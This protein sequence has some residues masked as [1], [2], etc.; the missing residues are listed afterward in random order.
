MRK[1]FLIFLAALSVFSCRS[2]ILEDRTECPSFLYF[3]VSNPEQFLG[4]QRV[5]VSAFSYPDRTFLACDTTVLSKMQD[6]SFYLEVKKSDAAMGHGAIGF[7]DG[8]LRDG[9]KWVVDEGS[10][11]IPLYRFNYT[12]PARDE[13]AVVPVEF[14]KDHC[15]VTVKFINIDSF[16]ATPGVFPFYVVIK[17]NT[18]GV[19]GFTG[20]P[21]RG[22]FVY[23]P[24]EESAGLFNFI[25]PRQF[26]KSLAMELYAKP[27]EYIEEG[28]VRTFNLWS[29]FREHDLS[30]DAKNLDDVYI[31]IDFT[32]S[33]YAVKVMPWDKGTDIEYEI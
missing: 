15:K 7:E 16:T 31:E 18:S 21:I 30:W 26:D 11:Y 13:S 24:E 14:V 25:V 29:F 22:S 23:E 5:F 32:E 1:V 6:K 2:I 20:N 9:S 19:D 4:Y 17:G 3:D 12:V 33:E 27:G 10:N 8:I 28:L